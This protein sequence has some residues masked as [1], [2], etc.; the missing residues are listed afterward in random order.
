M[1]RGVIVVQTSQNSGNGELY[2]Q[3]MID[4]TSVKDQHV[5]VFKQLVDARFMLMKLGEVL[6]W[7]GN[8]SAEIAML[9]VILRILVLPA[10]RML[11]I[12]FC[13]FILLRLLVLSLMLAADDCARIN[14]L[15]YQIPMAS[16]VSV[17]QTR[18]PNHRTV[19][20]ALLVHIC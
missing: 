4:H 18:C 14:L 12:P 20:S 1:K 6:L 9:W 16:L 19:R 11:V 8:S 7:T 15:L 10:I 3:V 5:R 2:E 17:S 13:Y